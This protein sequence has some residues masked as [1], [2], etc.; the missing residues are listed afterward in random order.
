MRF[1][2]EASE[3]AAY[4]HRQAAIL[5]DYGYG[6]KAIHTHL[7]ETNEPELMAIFNKLVGS[8]VQFVN[9]FDGCIFAATTVRAVHSKRLLRGVFEDM[10]DAL[11]SNCERTMIKV[12]NAVGAREVQSFVD[13]LQISG[14][15][16]EEIDEWRWLGA[17][18]FLFSIADEI[19]WDGVG[20]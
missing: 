10:I 13:G 11:S 17:A 6:L 4:I 8:A 15:S 16:A 2:R 1:A 19:G 7:S 3:R 20:V 5:Q 18:V 9:E 12:A 14:L